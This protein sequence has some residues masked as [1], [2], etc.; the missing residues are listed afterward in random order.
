MKALDR[1]LSNPYLHAEREHIYTN[2]ARWL[3]CSPRPVIVVDWSDLKA[4]KSWCL[5]RAAV[6]VGGRTLTILDMVFSGKQ[7]GTPAAEKL[8]LHRLKQLVPPAC[9]PIVAPMR[10]FATHGF[11]EWKRW[12][13]I[14]SDVCATAHS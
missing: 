1:L 9:K 13:G 7:Q 12:D 4:N 3:L 8:F 10:A 11:V 6:P 14:G 5:L 2:M